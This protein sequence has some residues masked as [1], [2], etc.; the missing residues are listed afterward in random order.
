MGPHHF[1]FA[2]GC[3]NRGKNRHHHVD[4][5]HREAETCRQ[6]HVS[7]GWHQMRWSQPAQRG[8]AGKADGKEQRKAD[9]HGK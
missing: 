5:D 9:D 8:T 1:A 4:Q 6:R 7:E 2:K 3:Q